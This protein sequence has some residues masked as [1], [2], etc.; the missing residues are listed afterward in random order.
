MKLIYSYEETSCHGFNYEYVTIYKAFEQICR[1]LQWEFFPVN[2]NN[3]WEE[4]LPDKSSD[5]I[6][7]SFDDSAHLQKP[8]NWIKTILPNCKIVILGG[9]AI[10]AS[11]FEQ[12]EDI[13]LVDLHLEMLS[14][15]INIYKERSY[16]VA[17]WMWT[18]S[19]Y[20]LNKIYQTDLPK[21]PIKVYDAIALF[22]IRE[23][24][25]TPYRCQLIEFF[26]KEK[27]SLL[28]NLGENDLQKIF[29]LYNKSWVSLG[30]TS[31]SWP[32]P[33]RS[34]KG[35]RDWIS[36][37]CGTVLVYDNHPDVI[38]LYTTDLPIYNYSNFQSIKNIINTIKTLSTKQY[39]D[40]LVEQQ[41]WVLGN[42]L[43]RQFTNILTNLLNGAI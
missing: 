17:R 25:V 15:T 31:S 36:P 32:S 14:E 19:E 16:N 33:R 39:N 20:L 24:N 35:F 9:D 7:V 23:Y 27:M 22:R 6:L 1:N 38:S 30:S 12:Y 18:T 21:S 42:T 8:I 2:K 37:F 13:K 40:I 10:Y 34:L 5:I 43:E 28:T 29:Q 41:Q 4:I 26:N 3:N 11:N